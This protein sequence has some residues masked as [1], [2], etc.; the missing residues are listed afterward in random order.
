MMFW[1]GCRIL[2]E[3]KIISINKEMAKQALDHMFWRIS[4]SHYKDGRA[5]GKYKLNFDEALLYTQENGRNLKRLRIP[6]VVRI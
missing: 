5:P 4:S 1:L 6:N 3:R 2:Q